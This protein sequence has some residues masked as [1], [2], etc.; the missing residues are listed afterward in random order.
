MVHRC[1]RLGIQTYMCCLKTR[2]GYDIASFTEKKTKKEIKRGISGINA[3]STD[4][5][6]EP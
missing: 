5:T 2:I 1:S 6:P 3:V 4:V